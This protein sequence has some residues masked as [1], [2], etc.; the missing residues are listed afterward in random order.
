MKHILLAATTISTTTTGELELLL[1]SLYSVSYETQ[2]IHRRYLHNPCISTSDYIVYN[3]VWV[4][5]ISPPR[6][7][8]SKG[9]AKP[10][11]KVTVVKGNG[12]GK[13]EGKM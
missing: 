6:Y 12:E 3:S 9:Y 2:D 11:V 1:K 13:N 7:G 8:I 5:I 4:Y 10:M